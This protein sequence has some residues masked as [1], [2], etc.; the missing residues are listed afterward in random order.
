VAKQF[1]YADAVALLGGSSPALA[2]FDRVLGGALLVGGLTGAGPALSLFDAKGEFVRFGHAAVTGLRE[3][4]RGL[5]RFDRT[6]RLHAAHAVIV[7]TAY[8]E[9]MD[10]DGLPLR[11][12][13]VELT[14]EDQVRLGEGGDDGGWIAGLLAADVPLPSPQHPYESNLER[15]RGWYAALSQRFVSYLGGLAVWERLDATAQAR[16]AVLLRDKVPELATDRYETLYRSLSLEIPEFDL[17]TRQRDAQATRAELRQGLQ[18]LEV[19]LR[20]VTSGRD[21]DQHRGAL[22]ATYRAQLDQPILGT[23]GT[24]EHLRMPA[25]AEIY[26]DPQFRVRDAGP[27][28]R[29][30]DEGWWYD[31]SPR[32]DLADFLAGHLTTSAATQAPLVVL[33]Q[34][35]AGKSALTRVLAARLPAADFLPVRVPLRDVPAD[36]DLQDQIEYALRTATGE[37]ITWPGLA[38]SAAGALPVVLLDGFDELLQATGVSQSDFL[39]RC[40]TFQHREA[41]QQ[42][43]VAVLVTSRT[44]VADRA[45]LPAGSVVLRLEPFTADQIDQ[46][47]EVWNRTNA[48]ALAASGL[49]P[50]PAQVAHRYGELASQ[51]LL[52][53]MLALYDAQANEVQ[54][55]SEA[56]LDAVGL[57]ER[58]LTT[59]AEREV[60]KSHTGAPE[61]MIAA[62][63]ESEMLRLSVA[64]FAMFNRSQ[65]WVTEADLDAD[66]TALSIGP[67]SDAGSPVG[68]R[69][70]LTAGQELLGRFFFIQRAQALR[71]E[72]R[73]QTYEFLHATFGEFLVARLA[74]RI[75]ADLA[76]REAAATLPLRSSNTEDSL[77]YSV[78]SFAPLTARGAILPFVSSFIAETDQPTLLVDLILRTFHI[79]SRWTETQS[80]AYQPVALRLVD[81]HAIYTLNL[82]LLAVAGGQVTAAQL[83]PGGEDP[84]DEWRRC[85][86]R[87]QAAID[88]YSWYTL[89]SQIRARRTWSGTKRDLELDLVRDGVVDAE[90]V[91]PYWIHDLPPGAKERRIRG[92]RRE[93][94]LLIR[95]TYHLRSEVF[96]DVFRHAL[97]P[98]LDTLGTAITHFSVVSEQESES[99]VHSLV[100]LWLASDLPTTPEQ[101]LS[102]AYTRAVHTVTRAWPRM[103]EPARNV[104]PALTLLL[105]MLS[106]DATDLPPAEVI[107]WCHA[108]ITDEN[109]D[110]Q[111]G[112]LLLD[113]A[114][115]A[116]LAEPHSQEAHRLLEAIAELVATDQAKLTWEPHL[117][118]RALTTLAELQLRDIAAQLFGDSEEFQQGARAEAPCGDHGS[119]TVS[120]QTLT[121]GCTAAVP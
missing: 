64:A 117:K 27:L 47:L 32:D 78:L 60:R 48:A 59:Y 40:A 89:V 1:S 98:L 97:E 18:K 115:T 104:H 41:V 66:L 49:R 38:R 46:W 13:E 105:R 10:L 90:P 79:A 28:D 14:R 4:V 21:P 84:L 118:R 61:A 106:R 75:L 24:Q 86:Q 12:A 6:Q 102:A 83:F 35:G 91:D 116:T 9:V 36:I 73:L 121:V 44:A 111:H 17:W 34:P 72:K 22:A 101:S 5:G 80:S 82:L 3:R 95:R 114:L 67:A 55:L 33:G 56:A 107:S 11:L 88:G 92:W 110:V 25:L 70:P 16:A 87:W 20:L 109:V 30:S 99:V 43:P 7:V 23:A 50:L 53:F 8:F 76:A 57:Y 77:L 94:H 45:R 54:A 58:L 2:A 68:F 51:P 74:V 52:L 112:P 96:D 119:V 81:R 31:T 120:K 37:R 108:I 62:L 71:D 39:E 65:Q 113:C 42:R 15:I 93:D 19:M 103:S 69:T 85:T 29:P 100:R 26:V 63:V